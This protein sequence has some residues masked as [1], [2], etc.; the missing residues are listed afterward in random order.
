MAASSSSS[1]SREVTYIHVDFEGDPVAEAAAIAVDAQCE[2]VEV[3]H[4]FAASPQRNPR[5]PRWH[6][7]GLSQDFLRTYG[8]PRSEELLWHLKSWLDQWP[9]A[10]LVAN[11]PSLESAALGRRVDDAGLPPWLVRQHCQCHVEAVHAKT[12]GLEV[13]GISCPGPVA[14]SEYRGWPRRKTPTDVVKQR[15]NYHCA[16][17]D[18]YE[19]YLFQKIDC[20]GDLLI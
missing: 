10:R 5:F 19:L 3:Y 7:H 6:V 20:W 16:L 15:H 11:G 4:D 12:M 1:S 9:T 8:F 17:Y 13:G 14:H 2:I 18:C